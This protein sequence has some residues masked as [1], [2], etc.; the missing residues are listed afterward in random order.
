MCMNENYYIK[1]NQLIKIDETWKSGAQED[2]EWSGQYLSQD[3]EPHRE[4]NK[5]LK[6][7]A[8]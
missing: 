7:L 8:I 3:V 6:Y 4:D 2:V 1:K 5:R